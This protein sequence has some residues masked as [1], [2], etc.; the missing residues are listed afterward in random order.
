VDLDE[1]TD[2]LYRLPPD[3]FIAARKDRETEA[4]AAGDRELAKEIAGLGK[5][6]TAAWVANLLAR[7]RPEEVAQLVEL[8]GLLR[9]AQENLA[10]D[11]M[12][13]LDVQRRRLVAEMTRQ[14]RQLAYQQ[15][16]PVSTTVAD[17]VE[18]TLRAAMTDPA[19]GEALQAGR[20][21]TAMSYSGLGTGRP[22]L[23]VVPPPRADRTT[24]RK[25]PTRKEPADRGGTA[26]DERRRQRERDR[27]EAERRAAEERRRRDL[28]EARAEAEA[29]AAAVE[30]AAAA[31]DAER[32]AFEHLRGREL[33]LESRIE[34]LTEELNE[35]REEWNRVTHD[36][37][38][39]E[40][41]QLAAARRAADAAR[42]RDKAE[43][44]LEALQRR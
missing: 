18:E 28:E 4:R 29:A 40:R 19:A 16:H 38:R 33:E 17:Q 20:L 35:A 26:A 3:E 1:V 6:S 39:A 32:E 25:P 15:G 24:E 34:E 13:A 31:E 7:E 2:E 43:R 36:R 27:A 22:D 30:E 44:R 42:A 21:T 9:E 14:A 23:R 41:R 37:S 12:R 10:G 11:E 5:P 8:G